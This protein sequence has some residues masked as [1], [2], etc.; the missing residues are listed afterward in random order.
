MKY[1]RGIIQIL[2]A[3]IGLSCGCTGEKL[4][5]GA[6]PGGPE[7][8]VEVRFF[9]SAIP[10]R[11]EGTGMAAGTD[12]L[13]TGAN[14]CVYAYRI[15]KGETNTTATGNYTVQTAGDGATQSLSPATPESG[16][17]SEMILPSGTFNFY[18]VSTNSSGAN[19]PN[20]PTDQASDGVPT[21]EN[22]TVSVQNGIDY[23]YA[24]VPEKTIT[25]GT[26]KAEIPL[27][28]KHAGAQVQLT[29]IFGDGAHAVD[30]STAQN[31][32]LARVT[33]QSTTEENAKMHLFNGEI[34][35][36]NLLGGSPGSTDT[37]YFKQMSVVTSGTVADGSN[38]PANQVATY[39]LL[40]LAKATNG[41]QKMKIKIEIG[42][43]VVGGSGA[44]ARTHTYTGELDASAGWLAGTSNRYTLTL[45]GTEIKF[46][47]VTVVPW[48]TGTG[49]EVGGITDTTPAGDSIIP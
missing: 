28:F 26:Q 13:V 17:A 20:F 40:P 16:T 27:T 22:T 41:S 12:K 29:I 36:G 46:S 11:A 2:T 3:V 24:A 33:V 47:S 31:F 43:L 34:R 23:L 42:N 45:S 38:T 32:N 4:L 14:V 44:Q 10:T 35:F 25:F 15:K 48:E 37:T 19:V 21:D 6:V 9:T 5:D 1:E 49:G 30:H 7:S 8:P 39:H 18:A